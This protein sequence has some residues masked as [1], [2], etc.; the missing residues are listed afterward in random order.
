MQHDPKQLN[1]IVPDW[2]LTADEKTHIR[3]R[4]LLFV[5]HNPVMVSQPR[6][7]HLWRSNLVN[8][9]KLSFLKPM[10]ILIVLAILL[11]GGVTFGAEKALPGD[12]LYPVK[13]HINEQV[14]GFVALSPEA[15]AAW[16][17]EAAG[18]RLEEAE[19]LAAQSKL[20]MDV[21]VRLEQ[22]F[23][24]FADRAGDR[25]KDFEERDAD[26]AAEIASNF[27]T[28]LNAHERILLA[29]GT[30][31]DGN[32]KP[33][34]D[35]LILKIKAEAKENSDERVK[36]ESQVTRGARVQA[37]A[38]GRM[39]SAQNKIAEVGRFIGSKKEELG[40]QATVQAEAR[41]KVASDSFIRGQVK[42]EA[43]QYGEAFVL[44][45]ESRAIAQEAKLLVQAKT[46]LDESPSP[47]TSPSPSV[48]QSGAS[49]QGHTEVESEG[50]NVHSNGRIKIDLGL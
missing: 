11:G 46:E 17:T 36:K 9:F 6:R 18:R 47:T 5:K 41:L 43:S 40:A 16:E 12:V 3:E 35:A 49:I 44:F 20:D 26:K 8:N 30:A 32:Q 39:K 10:P 28:S 29:I 2:E 15:K 19:E 25:I 7:L 21:R 24:A 42:L 27:E 31:K 50:G 38:E 1:K 13:I 34:I 14:R 48:S 23:Q 22:N 37:A 33:Q 4:L 45:G